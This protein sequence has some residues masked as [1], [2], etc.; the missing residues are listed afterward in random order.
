MSRGPQRFSH[1]PAWPAPVRAQ[2][3]TLP[4][5]PCVYLPERRSG[6]RAVFVRQMPPML[7][8]EFM[9]AGFRRS[10]LLVY[11]PVCAGC[12][13][14]VPIRV[15]V[16]HF[17]SDKSQ[18]RCSRRN[19]DLVV[20]AGD[21]APTD[22]KFGLYRRY[23]K[24]WHGREDGDSREEFEA[25]LYESPVRT[26]EFEYR[27]RA[28]NLLAV[29]ICDQCPLSL[30]SVYFYFDPA[31]AGRG[32]GTFGALY[33]IGHAAALGIPYYYLGYWVAGCGSM[34]YKAGFAVHQFLSTD[35]AWREADNNDDREC[36]L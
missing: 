20:S 2:L 15:D 7:Y 19:A 4:E 33:E 12:R 9:N 23:L 29:G 21:P 22:E 31:C 27:D 3:M 13:A 16:R 8:H 24:E 17:K 10:G 11:Q 6:R 35:G 5:H 28:S 14:C 34:A 36:N 26:I 32:L 18:R 25:F 30:S 1:Y